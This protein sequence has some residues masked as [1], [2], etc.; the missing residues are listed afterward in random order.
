MNQ[1]VLSW[2]QD[3]MLAVQHTDEEPRHKA[4]CLGFN[5]PATQPPSASTTP[6]APIM[7]LSIT[8]AL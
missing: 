5:H 1:V 3:R 2:P 4:R 8:Q 7:M 6:S